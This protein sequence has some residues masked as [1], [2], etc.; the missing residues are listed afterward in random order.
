MTSRE[1]RLQATIDRL[2]LELA[3]ERKAH[4]VTREERDTARRQARRWRRVAELIHSANQPDRQP[5][6]Q[7]APLSARHHRC[8]G[9]SAHAS[10]EA[11]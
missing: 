5:D 11:S 2:A 1:E 6:P 10:Q 7:P 9:P 3:E 4:A 8:P